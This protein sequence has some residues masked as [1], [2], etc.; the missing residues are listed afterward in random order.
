M[1]NK[2]SLI[3]KLQAQTLLGFKGLLAPIFFEQVEVQR[4]LANGIAASGQTCSPTVQQAASAKLLDLL[5]PK[6]D[7]KIVHELGLDED[8]KDITK[9]L[10]D[11]IKKS[12]EL[13]ALRY[14]A[15]EKL[16]DIQKIGL[17]NVI[18]VSV[19]E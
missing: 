16:E 14:K 10:F 15:G 2:S 3:V 6:E 7:S 11:Q 13:Q 5:A 12:S 9:S 8:T 19:D 18:E 1:Y 17:S 4:S